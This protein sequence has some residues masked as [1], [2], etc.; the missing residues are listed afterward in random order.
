[1]SR[2]L[3]LL[4]LLFGGPA[5]AA[6]TSPETAAVKRLIVEEAANSPLPASLALALAKVESDFDPRAVSAAGARGL[7]QIMPGTA[8]DQFGVAAD[9]L[10]NPR[11]NAQLGIDYLA[12]LIRLYGG[13][14]DL[15]LSHYNG[16]PLSGT[17]RTA[18]AHSFT[19]DYVDAVLRWEKVFAAAPAAP[20]PV[21]VA[22]DGWVPARTRVGP[23]PPLPPPPAPRLWLR[24]LPAAPDF[25]AV[26]ARAREARL[27]LADFGGGSR[28]LQIGAD[29]RSGAEQ[30][31]LRR[32]IVDQAREMER[33]RSRVDGR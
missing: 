13:R 19:R 23:P 7:M 17:G 16:G 2:L 30:A 20:G 27:K 24:P 25:A 29:D 31:S 32:T 18:I 3:V 6:P 12:R 4:V 9:E 15:A 5:L 10:W 1:M 28:W 26:E 21:Q 22:A 33:L 8:R 14:W 11:L